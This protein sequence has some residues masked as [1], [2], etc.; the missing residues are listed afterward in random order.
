MSAAVRLCGH[1]SVFEH[2]TLPALPLDARILVVDDNEDILHAARLLLKRHFTGVQTLADPSQLAALTRRGAFDV[3]LL[4]MNF[5]AGADSGADG[6][7]RLSEVL[8]IDPQAVVVMVTAHSDVELAV[9]A[10]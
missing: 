1:L 4:D 9:D 7:A 6:L 3:L 5:T 8:A 10:I 2:M